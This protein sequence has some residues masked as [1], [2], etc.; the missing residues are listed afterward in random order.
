MKKPL[1]V[2]F[3]S[4]LLLLVAS[5]A[6]NASWSKTWAHLVG[7][8][9][10]NVN[11][12]TIS[13]SSSNA[14]V[15]DRVFHPLSG[16]WDSPANSDTDSMSGI[17]TDTSAY[18]A[19][20]R[21][22]GSAQ[23]RSFDLYAEAIATPDP[24]SQSYTWSNIAE[25]YWT[26]QAAADGLVRFDFT[27]DFHHDLKTDVAG[28]FAYGNIYADFHLY[29]PQWGPWDYWRPGYHT[30]LATEKIVWDGD[31]F[32]TMASVPISVGSLF[33][34][35]ESGCLWVRV[36]NYGGAYTLIP[37]PPAVL[38]VGIGVGFVSWLRRRRAI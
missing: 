23:T 31:D 32:N 12:L 2:S 3:V 20:A 7:T 24:I 16:V 9:Y 25:Q 22:T 34:A 28:E 15:W 18:A 13:Q 11:N 33:T 14:Y 27:Y 26:F 19:I 10:T 35:G 38:L 6:A 30:I 21:A 29:R 4:I 37:S 36:Q 17:T 5:P 8:G 1:M